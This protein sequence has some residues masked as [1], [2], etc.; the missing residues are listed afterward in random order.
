M[1]NKVVV[2]MSRQDVEKFYPPHG[3]VLISISDD[4]Q[5]QAHLKD[6]TWAR[7]FFHHFLDGGYDEQL[8]AYSGHRFRD[9]YQSYLMPEGAAKLRHQIGMVVD[10]T[11][12]IVVNCEYGRSRSAAVAKYISETHDFQLGQDA[13]EAN[14]TVYKLLNNDRALMQ[15]I[16]ESDK[17]ARKRNNPS[18]IQKM[19]VWLKLGH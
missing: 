6:T 19:A 15:A 3:A 8:V 13:S 1:A 11:E 12:L 16:R 14:E 18:L 5:Y 17:L 4:P 7:V 10:K 9:I 2:Y